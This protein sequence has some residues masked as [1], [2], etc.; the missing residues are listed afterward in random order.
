MLESPENAQHDRC[1]DIFQRPDG[2]YGFEEFRRDVEDRGRWTPVSYF[3]GLVFPTREAA[4]EAALKAVPWLAEV[5]ASR[6]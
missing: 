3:L 5:S 2:T 4:R 1:V 6:S